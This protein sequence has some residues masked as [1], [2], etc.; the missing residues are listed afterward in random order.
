MAVIDPA[1]RGTTGEKSPYLH[2]LRASR[3]EF[4]R[5]EPLEQCWFVDGQEPL[6]APETDYPMPLA[7]E[8]SHKKSGGVERTG[9]RY[10]TVNDGQKRGC[11]Y[12]VIPIQARG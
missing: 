8:T 9:F 12:L 4:G 2:S 10:R 6:D 5:L 11:F 3:P 1:E 7:F